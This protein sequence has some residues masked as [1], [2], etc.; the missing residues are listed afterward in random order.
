[1]SVKVFVTIAAIL[2]VFCNASTLP[3]AETVTKPQD[4]ITS[5]KPQDPTTS[6]EPQDPTTSSKPQ[7]STTSPKPLTTTTSQV[8]G[9]NVQQNEESVG[10]A[11]V[12]LMN[13]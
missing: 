6:S 13:C 5:S 2:F 12:S 8:E 9:I 10:Q 3:E 11:A 7:D 1:M 4:A